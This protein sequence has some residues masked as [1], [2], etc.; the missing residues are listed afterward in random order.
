ME[1]VKDLELGMGLKP[2]GHLARGKLLLVLGV[3]PEL[4]PLLLGA[5]NPAGPIGQWQ[6]FPPL[7]SAPFICP[8]P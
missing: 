4:K 7:E 1:S 3:D 2:L 8:T 6:L 5:S